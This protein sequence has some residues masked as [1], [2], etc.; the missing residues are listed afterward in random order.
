[1]NVLSVSLLSLALGLGVSGAAL[2]KAPPK[3]PKPPGSLAAVTF[4]SKHP[5]SLGPDGMP[6]ADGMSA[7]WKATYQEQ[8]S[9]VTLYGTTGVG[10]SLPNDSYTVVAGAKPPPRAPYEIELERVATPISNPL[11]DWTSG[12]SVVGDGIGLN[13]HLAE[14]TL[15]GNRVW[16]ANVHIHAKVI[17]GLLKALPG[18]NPYVKAALSNGSDFYRLV[19]VERAVAGGDMVVAG[20][21]LSPHGSPRALAN[22][23]DSLPS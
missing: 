1:M 10:V 6:S 12:V 9:Q 4:W 3:P 5:G 18:L 16:I 17:K 14:K 13:V 19:V 15:L 8:R 2:A 21:F 23:T 20:D 22:F 11:S 7:Y